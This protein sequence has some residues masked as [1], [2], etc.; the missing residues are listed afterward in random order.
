MAAVDDEVNAMDH[1]LQPLADVATP[2]GPEPAPAGDAVAIPGIGRLWT[3]YRA[4]GSV[5]T[6]SAVEI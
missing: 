6:S 2:A 4:C 3:I 5:A 1:L